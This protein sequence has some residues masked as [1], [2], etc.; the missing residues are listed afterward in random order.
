MSTSLSSM[1]HYTI[2]A[3]DTPEASPGALDHVEVV[4]IPGGDTFHLLHELRNSGL[5]DTLRHHI[6]AGGAIYGGSAGAIRAGRDI[7]IA[8]IADTNDTDLDT[9]RALDYLD[10]IDILPHY[11]DDGEAAAQAHSSSTGRPLL[12]FPENSNVIALASGKLRN[13]GPSDAYVIQT[14]ASTLVIRT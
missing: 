12:C 1:E 9:F 3:W 14:A 6:D 2:E 5:I 7:A 11:T 4:A 13:V 10:G 8:L